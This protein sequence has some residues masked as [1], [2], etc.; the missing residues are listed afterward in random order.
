[1]CNWLYQQALDHP[2]LAEAVLLLG[3]LTR[4]ASLFSRREGARELN[5]SIRDLFALRGRMVQSLQKI[6]GCPSG[7]QSESTI[8]L[9]TIVFCVE[10]SGP[11][12]LYLS[13]VTAPN[14]VLNK[15][16]I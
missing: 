13:A 7:V 4:T 8:I 16:Q 2:V 1:M 14:P 10:V 5:R 3:A 11:G 6:L 15:T 9:I 12:L